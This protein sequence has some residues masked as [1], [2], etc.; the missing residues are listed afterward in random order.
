VASRDLN[1]RLAF[2]AQVGE[3]AAERGLF[4]VGLVGHAG[5]TWD[6]VRGLPPSVAM[7]NDTYAVPA[8]GVTPEQR[9][10]QEPP[11]LADFL[12]ITQA[13]SIVITDTQGTP[14]PL[15]ERSPEF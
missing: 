6:A 12:L 5:Q 15:L 3:R 7:R 14:P 4:Q 11:S 9:E 1:T 13:V 2:G 10:F 8:L